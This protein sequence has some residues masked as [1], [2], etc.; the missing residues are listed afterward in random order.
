MQENFLHFLSINPAII[1]INGNTIGTIDNKNIMELDVIPY[2]ERLFVTVTPVS[3]QKNALPFTYQ[4]NNSTTV[5]TD[6]QN[7]EIIPFPNNHFDI[8]TQNFYYQDF[9]YS[10]I[11]LNQDVGDYFISI[12]SD[13]S[14]HITIFS[15]IKN[16]L[17]IDIPKLN[18]AKV[19]K[20]KDLITIQGIIDSENYYL[21]VI[22][23][24]DFNILFNDYVHS[25]E[26]N[27]NN[28]QVLK[29]LKDILS[30]L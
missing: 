13:N 24:T 1:S 19:E 5:S 7:I 28:I 15:G 21:V 22:N 11:I 3:Y 10:K 27:I 23:T 14:S 20:H 12:I 30:P 2:T 18:F 9:S 26:E 6:N 16:L 25:I 17:N 8:V 29:N 4:I